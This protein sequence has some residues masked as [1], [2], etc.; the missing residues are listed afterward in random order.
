MIALDVELVE[1]DVR[2][3]DQNLLDERV[4]SLEHREIQY[5]GAVLIQVGH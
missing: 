1:G 4:D 5:F 2:G 3:C